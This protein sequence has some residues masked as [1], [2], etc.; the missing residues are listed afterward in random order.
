MS[1]CPVFS[2]KK[3]A[4]IAYMLTPITFGGADRV[5]LNFLKNVDRER[6]DIRP[7]LLLRPWEEEPYFAREIRQH[8]YSYETVPV[9]VRD[10]HDPF[11]ILRAITSAYSI[12]KKASFDLL[13]T[14]GYFAD[15]IG[16][17][18]S[19]ICRI[20][21]VA[22]CHGFIS[23]DARLKIYNKLDKIALRLCRKVIVVSEE[24]KFD[25]VGSGVQ[26][27]KLIIIQNAVQNSHEEEWL[28]AK[29]LEKRRLLAIEDDDFVV[30]YAGRLSQEKGVQHLIDACALLKNVNEAIQA[31]IL[32]DGP[33]RKDLEEMA[34]VKGLQNTVFFLG[35]KNDV[36]EWFPAMDVFVLPSFTEGTPMAL[37][38]AMSVGVPVI[39]SAVGGIPKVIDNMF[40]GCLIEPGDA[41]GIRDKILLLKKDKNLR[42]EISTQEIRTVRDRFSTFNWCR[43]IETQY[44]QTMSSSNTVC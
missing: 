8:G 9:A 12:M 7:I 42:E 35:F 33:T 4:R 22:T 26:E 5:S 43:M 16:A 11:R 21:H 1:D 40:N 13:H 44:D 28:V 15:I 14:H 2:S 23:N 25:L 24:L 36:E 31:I 37:L 3:R 41:E 39:A 27:S 19:K 32:G 38:E 34:R 18:V 29:A 17:V 30:G 10:S 6:F 20:P